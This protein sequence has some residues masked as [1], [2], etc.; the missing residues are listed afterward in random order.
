LPG[1]RSASDRPPPGTG[2]VSRFIEGTDA[3][4]IGGEATVIAPK[5]AGL[6]AEVLVTDN[7]AAHAGDLLVRLRDRNYR[8]ALAKAVSAVAAKEAALANLNAICHL[9]N[10]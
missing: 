9:R 6:I 4:Y 3:A 8:A 10:R 1:C 7:Q 5:V 2:I